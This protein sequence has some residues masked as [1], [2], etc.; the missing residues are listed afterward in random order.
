MS[1]PAVCARCGGTLKPSLL[2]RLCPRCLL[3]SGLSPGPGPETDEARWVAPPAALPCNLGDYELLETLGQGGMGVVYRARQRSLHRIVA[4]KMLRSEGFG[5]PTVVERFR[6][7][8]ELAAQLQHPNLVAI[9]E[10]GEVNGQPFFSMDF[11]EGTDLGRILARSGA[12]G[13]E[14][15]RSA[16]WLKAMA[17]AAHHAHQRGIIHRDLK[18]SNVLID[19]LDQPHI[20]DFGLARRLTSDLNLTLTGQVLGSPSYLPPEQAAGRPASVESDVYSLGAILYHLLTGRPPFHADSLTALLRQVAETDPVMPRLLN[21]STPR[22][23]ETVCLKALEKDASR[24][25]RTAQELAEDLGRFL[26]GQPTRA[27][28]VG[29]V[30]RVA[31]FCRRQPVRAGLVAALL[32]TVLLAVAGITRQWRRAERERDSAL[33]HVYAGD[34]KLAQLTLEDG[35]LGGARRL[36]DKHRPA[37]GTG[38]EGD[39]RGWEWRYLWALCRDEAEWVLTRQ[40]VAFA[41]LNLSP[42]GARLAVRQLAGNIDLWDWPARVKLGTL[43]NQG[44][45]RA[46]GFSPDSTLLV[47]AN[48]DAAGNPV[49]SLWDPGTR[50]ILRHLPQPSAVA[51]L[52]FSPDGSL[53]ATYH[54]DAEVRLWRFPSGSLVTHFPATPAFNDQMRV[55]LFSPDGTLLVLGEIDGRIRVVQLSGDLVAE[56]PTPAEGNGVSALAFSPDGRILASGYGYSVGAIHLWDTVT[57]LPKGRL[58]GHRGTIAGL[59]FDPDGQTLYSASEDQTLRAWDVQKRLPTA[60]WQGHT[61]RVSGLVLAPGGRTLVSCAEDGTVRLWRTSAPRSPPHYAVLPIR[62][63]PFDAPFSADSRRLFT[64]SATQP[65]TVWDVAT[66]TVVESLPALGT[67]H[68]SIAVS[69]DERLIVVGRLDGTL[70]AWDRQ[71]QRLIKE[72][73]ASSLPIYGLRFFDQ[74]RSLLSMASIPGQQMDCR[75]WEVDSWREVSFGSI[76]VGT[77]YGFTSSPDGRSLALSYLNQPVRLWDNRTGRLVRTFDSGGGWTPHFSPDGRWLVAAVD[78]RAKLWE[79]SSGR[80]WG[81]FEAPANSIVSV[82]FSPDGRRLVTGCGVGMS[83]RPA[84]HLWDPV[85][86]RELLSLHSAGAFTGWTEFSPDGNTLLAVSWH[87]LAE[88]WRAPSWET[89]EAIERTANPS[90]SPKTALTETP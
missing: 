2:G 53:L 32:L 69:P 20:T 90:P 11:V 22:D 7:E 19:G 4:V 48:R 72:W 10:V 84:V 44:W 26:E 25:Y 56:L 57:W 45:E 81:V 43:T 68:H 37:R 74:G 54:L 75:R 58:E 16:R 70:Q 40:G 67:N 59:V 15:R 12:N 24:R 85:T 38:P 83:L 89:I 64:A 82:A 5:G 30:G 28:P 78:H 9:H 42:D 77:C 35:N 61:D 55:P 33:G 60:R 80:L 6:A 51:S 86:Q 65:V 27:R 23:L 47:S 8:A 87:G 63:G 36:L 71:K 1:E 17:E 13:V 79:V 34:L 18:P 88:L 3:S 73:S 46:W 31:R 39:R 76:D 52:A 50:R 49:L 62:I 14:A 29:A 41:G 66:L 21:S